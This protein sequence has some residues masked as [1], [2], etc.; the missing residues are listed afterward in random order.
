MKE[1]IVKTLIESV[2]AEIEYHNNLYYNLDAPEISDAEY[3]YMLKRLQELEEEYPQYAVGNSP[4]QVIGGVANEGKK[5]SHKIQMQSLQDVF[6]IEEA[7]KYFDKN[8]N[9]YVDVEYKIDGL[10]VSVEYEKGKLIRASTRGDGY[11]GEDVTENAMNVLG[12]PKTID[13]DE[14]LEVRGEIYLSHSDFEK[15]NQKQE[16]LG[17]KLFANARNC[18]AGTLRQL[19]P[20]IVKERKLQCMIFN[21]QQGLENIKSHKEQLRFLDNLGF[22]VSLGFGPFN[23]FSQIVDTIDFI[24]ENRKNIAFPV[25]GAV[26][27]CDDI[28][29]RK[30]IGVVTKTPLWAFAYKYPPKQVET[31]LVDIILQVGRIGRITPVAVLEPVLIDGTTVTKATLHN[32][33]NIDRLD[34]RIGDT[35]VLQKAGEIIPEIVKVVKDKRPATAKEYKIQ[36]TCPC[37]SAK[38]TISK[39]KADIVCENPSCPAQIL[40]S[41]EHFVSKGCMNI[42][43]LGSESIAKLIDAGY[44]KDVTDFYK[45]KDKKEELIE[46]GIIGKKKTIEKLLNNIEKSKDNNFDLVICSLGVKNVGKTVS[47]K[48]AEKYENVFN[49]LEWD[50]TNV[51]KKYSEIIAFEGVSTEIANSVMSLIANK[52]DT[53]YEL[54]L[55]GVNMIYRKEVLSNSLDGKTFVITGSFDVKRDVIADLITKN[56]GKI[57]GSVSKKTNFLVSGEDCGSKLQKAEELGVNIISLDELKSMMP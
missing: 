35:I 4:T 16:S 45:L 49:L 36:S 28:D 3:D 6:S 57:S 38:L 51:D 10:S 13:Y 1:N 52:S 18:A 47:K 29:T 39:D 7:Q 53:L 34:L 14:F 5:V 22:C 33:A 9:T 2:R 48:L 27:K 31:K 42:D 43:G 17:E 24:G 26:I 55:L 56:G 20:A 15:I 19:N 41:L 21:V 32:Q 25:D 23:E 40:R 44:L 30:E 11:V 46:K 50:I 8:I 54:E 12:I 37:C